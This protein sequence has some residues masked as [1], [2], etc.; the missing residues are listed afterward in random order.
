MITMDQADAIG[1]PSDEV[2]GMIGQMCPF[3][4]GERGILGTSTCL[5]MED[6]ENFAKIAAKWACTNHVD[7]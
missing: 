1:I 2:K 7:G 3:P 5:I 4:Q 6:I